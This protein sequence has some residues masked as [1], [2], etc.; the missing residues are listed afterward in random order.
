M[1]YLTKRKIAAILIILYTLPQIILSYNWIATGSEMIQDMGVSFALSG[2]VIMVAGFMTA[3]GVWHDQKMYKIL[4]MI[5]FGLN[6]LVALP[7]ILFAPSLGWR[8]ATI[9]AVVIFAAL[10]VLLLRRTPEPVTA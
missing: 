1:D 8:L 3:F 9:S 5:I 4:A 2:L 7:G 10:L 6:A